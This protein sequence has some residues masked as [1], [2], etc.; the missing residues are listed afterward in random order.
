MKKDAWGFVSGVSVARETSFLPQ[1]FMDE[2]AATPPAEAAVRL[3]RTWFGPADPLTLFDAFARQR[4]DREFDDIE[5]LSPASWPVDLLRIRFATDEVR[6]GIDSVPDG[7][8]GTELARSLVRLSV[9]AGRYA[10]QF[11]EQFSSPL[12]RPGASARLAASLLVDSAEL[13]ITYK[14]ADLADDEILARYAEARAQAASAKVAL[15]ALKLGIPRE[16]LASFFFRGRLITERARGFLN[17][18]REAAALALL[19]EGCS[20]GTEDDF[21]LSVAAQSKGNAFSAA[22]V[23]YYLLGFLQQERHL[24]LAVYSSLGRLPGKEAA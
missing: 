24:R 12:P 11:A 6:K 14:I 21:L 4:R 17:D 20:P 10:E 22:R 13:E 19:P 15:R 8:D 23:L 18:Y 2:L 7:A 5:K 16:D 3:G 1:R 9:R